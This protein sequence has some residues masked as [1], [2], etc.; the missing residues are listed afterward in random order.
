M[1]NKIK[2]GYQLGRDLSE[3]LKNAESDLNP[4]L[5]PNDPVGKKYDEICKEVSRNG[6]WSGIGFKTYFM[7]NPLDDYKRDIQSRIIY[8]D[9]RKKGIIVDNG[10]RTIENV[11]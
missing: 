11:L 6:A 10:I 3:L 7:L 1:F 4:L 8:L 2:Q 9:L 5:F